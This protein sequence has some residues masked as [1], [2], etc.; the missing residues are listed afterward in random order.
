MSPRGRPRS[1]DR[2]EALK[3]AMEVFW[4]R[5]YEGSSLAELTA[6]MRINSPSLYAAFGSKRQLFD[7]AVAHYAA[8]DGSTTWHAFASRPTARAA[9]EALLRSTA[10]SVTQPGKPPGCLIVLAAT[11]CAAENDAVRDDLSDRRRSLVEALRMRL[12]RGIAEG[13]LP[14]GTDTRA[15]ATFFTTVLQGMSVQARDGATREDLMKALDHLM[16]AWDHLL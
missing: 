9:V 15:L 2:T 12:E 7:E 3:R 1:F 16:R 13:D 5:G 4:E 14:S 11:N 8:T 10:E 6:A